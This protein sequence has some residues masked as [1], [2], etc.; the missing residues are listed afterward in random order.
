MANSEYMRARESA[1]YANSIEPS[2]CIGDA[3]C[4]DAEVP[5]SS[6]DIGVI[7]RD[8]RNG[9]IARNVIDDAVRRNQDPERN[10]RCPFLTEGNKC[11]IYESRPIVCVVWGIGGLPIDEE[12][13]QQSVNEW[14][15]TGESQQY[16]NMLLEQS[17]CI[18]CR[19]QTCFNSTSVEAN[20]AA[21]R[22]PGM[23][24]ATYPIMK[25]GKPYT[26]TQFV[27]TEL[28]NL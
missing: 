4:C 9:K 16:P 5:V 26:L 21:L 27:T 2:S 7:I 24:Q 17:T 8:I 28:P 1:L 22:A 14:K 10:N 3:A 23:A 25:K 18:G 11:S 20:E 13:Y 6:G 19:I 12:S 15:V